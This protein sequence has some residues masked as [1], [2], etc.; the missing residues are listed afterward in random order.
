MSR[1]P[2]PP[3]QAS[4]KV[5]VLDDE[6]EDQWLGG[7]N[8]FEAGPSNLGRGAPSDDGGNYTAFYSQLSM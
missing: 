5:I 8:N 2:T 3:C 6:D 1:P 4:G 7:A